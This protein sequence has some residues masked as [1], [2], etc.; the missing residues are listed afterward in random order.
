MNKSIKINK[1]S[2]EFYRVV[3]ELKKNFCTLSKALCKIT[4]FFPFDHIVIAKFKIVFL[5]N[6][7][8]RRYVIQKD[9]TK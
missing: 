7:F 2:V 4:L 3:N 1:S 8:F 5:K 6:M 9:Y